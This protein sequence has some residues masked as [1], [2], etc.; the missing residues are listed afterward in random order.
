MS[1][2]DLNR[3]I[4][5]YEELGDMAYARALGELAWYYDNDTREAT[6]EVQDALNKEYPE[7]TK[8]NIV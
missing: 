2:E 4:E 1:I 6:K 8:I 3:D 5:E 7:Y